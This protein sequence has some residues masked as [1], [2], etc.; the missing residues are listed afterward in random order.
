MVQVKVNEDG[1]GQADEKRDQNGGDGG[2]ERPSE[3][4]FNGTGSSHDKMR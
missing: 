4:L 2:G 3:P 1:N